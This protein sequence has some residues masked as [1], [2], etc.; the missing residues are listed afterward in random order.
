MNHLIKNT[1]KSSFEFTVSKRHINKKKILHASVLFQ[2]AESLVKSSITPYQ[3][4]I[5]TSLTTFELD[6]IKDAYLH[7]E[8]I[9]TNR[10][11]KLD[12]SSLELCVT[13][14]KKKSVQKD[15][16]CKATFGYTFEKI[17]N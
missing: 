12:N 6:I 5:N 10:I 2:K 15:V 1:P 13:V 11:Q 4:V 16:I 3:G 14:T 17:L 9:V 8:L 7:D